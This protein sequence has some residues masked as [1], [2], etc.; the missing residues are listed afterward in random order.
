MKENEALRG[1]LQAYRARDA[2]ILG[3]GRGRA[4]TRPSWASA[5]HF[6]S[7]LGELKTAEMKKNEQEAELK[8]LVG[9]N[10]EESLAPPP[11]LAPV[12]YWL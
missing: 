12:R 3:R 11:V 9:E 5:S 7:L 6:E 10:E 2:H 8:A 1:S 4:M